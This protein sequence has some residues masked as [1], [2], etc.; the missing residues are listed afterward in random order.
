MTNG[1]MSQQRRLPVYLLLDCSESM[2][3]EPQEAVSQ[4]IRQLITDLKSDPMAIETAWISVICFSSKATQL[5]PLIDVLQ[6]S[7][8]SLPLG[9][10]TKLGAAFDLLGVCIERDVQKSSNTH[11]GDWKPIVYLLTDGVPTDNWQEAV[12]RFKSAY[13]SVNIVAIGCGEDVDVGIMSTITPNVLMMQSMSIDAMKAFFKWVSRSVSTMSCGMKDG[14]K[15]NLPKPPVDVVA[16]HANARNPGSP[17]QV[18]LAIR[19]QEQK[20]GYLIRYRH[21]SSPS[22]TYRADKAYR[23]GEDYFSEAMAGPSGQTLDSSKFTGASPC[24]YCGRKGWTLAKDRS[25]LECND[26]IGGGAGRAQV[27]FVLDVT[28]SMAGEISGVKDNIGDFINY[29]DKDGLYVEVGLIAFRDLK[30]GQFPELPKFGGDTFTRNVDG[31]QEVVSR[32]RAR[33]GGN[34]GA[35][36]SL[37]ALVL[38]TEQRFAEESNKVIILITDERPWIPD[39]KVETMGDVI[40]ALSKARIDQLHIVIPERLNKYFAPLLGDVKG[41]LYKLEADGRGG[42]AFKNLIEDI[43]RN[44]TVITRQG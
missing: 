21:V 7:P 43:R 38:A 22:G 25:S 14:E 40:K 42:V 6:F 19:C 3:G 11:K 15:F 31:F 28:G 26:S 44:I 2:V 1:S 29:I 34:N 24:P 23:V 13:P 30:A 18:I 33:G 9:P 16:M 5:V 12:R 35:E 41:K 20:K 39:D 17:S 37:A 36:S 4:G 27:M 8:P 32:L 10:G